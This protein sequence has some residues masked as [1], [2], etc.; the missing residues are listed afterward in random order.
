MDASVLFDSTRGVLG[1]ALRLTRSA[2]SL[3][4]LLPDGGP[5]RASLQLAE[6]EAEASRVVGTGRLEL[7]TTCVSSRR[8]NHLSYA[9]IAVEGCTED[10]IV[11]IAA[12]AGATSLR[13]AGVS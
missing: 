12:T 13:G 4:A 11:S 2:R 8:S 9:P 3:R 5:P 6:G 1:V 10:G 7:P